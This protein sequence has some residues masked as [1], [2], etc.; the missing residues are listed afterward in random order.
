MVRS[1]ATTESGDRVNGQRVSSYR[2]NSTRINSARINS[3]RLNSY[4]IEGSDHTEY[5]QEDDS[6][7]YTTEGDVLFDSDDHQLRS[8]AETELQTIAD[9]I[10]DR[11]DDYSIRV[12]GHTDNLPSQEYADNDE[13]S[14]D[15]AQSVADWL[16]DNTDVTSGEIT[17]EGMGEDHPRSDNDTDEGRQQNR[18]VVITVTPDDYEPEIDYETEE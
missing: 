16:T 1:S 3:D 17:A 11:D 2:I 10:A 8:D 12:E 4:R 15:R 18:R 5:S 6:I 7:S 14:E 9:D 13:L